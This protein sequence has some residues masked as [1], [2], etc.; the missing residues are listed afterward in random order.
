[1][2]APRREVKLPYREMNIGCPHCRAPLII[3]TVMVMYVTV[4]TT[5]ITKDRRYCTVVL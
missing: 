4:V 2:A 3:G 1:M 5:G